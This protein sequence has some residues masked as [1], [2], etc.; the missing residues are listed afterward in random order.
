MVSRCCFQAA[1]HRIDHC[2]GLAPVG[3]FAAG[4]RAD[5]RSLGRHRPADDGGGAVGRAGL[6]GIFATPIQN[7]PRERTQ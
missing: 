1:Y 7:A 5:G 3:C 4:S 6:A 2:G